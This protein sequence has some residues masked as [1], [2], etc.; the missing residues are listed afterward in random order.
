MDERIDAIRQELESTRQ[1]FHDLA[2]SLSQ[3]A[4]ERDSVN[5]AWTVGALTF[6]ITVGLQALPLDVWLI[7]HLGWLPLPPAGLFH[8]LNQW[9]T[10]RGGRRHTPETVTEVYDRAHEQVLALLETIRPEEW[11]QALHYP[12]WDPL[13][14]GR[15]SVEDLFHYPARHFAQHAAEISASLTSTAVWSKRWP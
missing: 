1:A 2:G 3:E 12:D 6:H 5:P 9:I 8:R 11:D 14:S 4:W 7:R 10:R 15:V 13:L